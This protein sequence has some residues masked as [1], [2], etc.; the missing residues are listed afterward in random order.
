MQIA[1]KI[2]AND[3]IDLDSSQHIHSN[4]TLELLLMERR[5]MGL[6]SNILKT[7]RPD[8]KPAGRHLQLPACEDSKTSPLV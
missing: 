5:G 1:S 3:E 7:N 6:N 2:F 8:E 4:P